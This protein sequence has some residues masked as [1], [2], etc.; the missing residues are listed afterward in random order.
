VAE[1]LV[2]LDAEY[3][4][5]Q[6]NQCAMLKRSNMERLT[7]I[8]GMHDVL[9]VTSVPAFRRSW[10][11]ERLYESFS[12]LARRYGFCFIDTPEVERLSLFVRS[13]GSTSDIATKEM[14]S[15]YQGG[16]EL[17]LRPEGSAAVARALL[18]SGLTRT[19]AVRVWYRMPMFRHE[20]PQFGRYRRH[21]QQ[22]AE[23]VG[24]ESASADVEIM[25]L[26][27]DYYQATGLRGFS[28]RLN[29]IGD[30][31]CRGSYLQRLTARLME[32]ADE[33]CA[34]CRHRVATNPLR[35]FDCKMQAD[36]DR[37]RSLPRVVDHLCDACVTHFEQVQAGL[38]T[39]GVPYVLDPYL[40]RGID[41]YTRTTFEV[42]LD[43]PIEQMVTLTG[44]GRYDGLYEILGGVSVPAVGFGAGMERLLLALEHQGALSDRPP[45]PAVVIAVVDAALQPEVLPLATRLRDEGIS[46]T[47]E[48]VPR[49]IG[50]QLAA[51]SETGA[52]YAVI[53]APEE[54]ASGDVLLKDLGANQQ[55]RVRGS[56]LAVHILRGLV[57]RSG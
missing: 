38:K 28:V 17:C 34:D 53:L 39:V 42:V 32:T 8:Q 2:W 57:R 15:W 26:L 19:E 3:A 1:S 23:I 47:F 41:Y 27:C 29:S 36:R 48:H 21:V 46:T 13:A 12:N 31:A 20:R 24:V 25:R 11:W 18:E 52:R 14:Y 54:W 50:K 4:N 35:V 9:P 37:S 40:V 10:N 55:S 7:G 30:D 49:R 16:R 51:A 22:G 5:Q 44:G 56:D 33:Y 6:S 45:A 43:E